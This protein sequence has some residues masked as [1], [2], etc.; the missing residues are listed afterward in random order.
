MNLLQRS[1]KA[2]QAQLIQSIQHKGIDPEMWET[3]V[4]MVKE[5]Y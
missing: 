3:Y 4:L 2:V 1:L 5:M